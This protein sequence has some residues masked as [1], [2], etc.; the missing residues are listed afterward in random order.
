MGNSHLSATQPHTD[1]PISRSF[2]EDQ[3]HAW[4]GF[5]ADLAS[6]DA[7]SN[8]GQEWI[9]EGIGRLLGAR[10]VSLYL[11]EESEEQKLHKYKVSETG[12]P[13]V[14]SIISHIIL[15]PTLQTGHLF[16]SLRVKSSIH[17]TMH[18]V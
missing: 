15:V 12:I 18:A 11:Y 3:V 8:E 4:L 17:G 6:T 13:P 14:S 9:A 2:N 1:A 16:L 7:E 10:T 5:L